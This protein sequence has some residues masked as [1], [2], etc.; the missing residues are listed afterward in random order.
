MDAVDVGTDQL[1]P[2]LRDD[3]RIT[4][5]EQTDIRAFQ[6]TTIYDIITVDVSFISLRDIIDSIKRFS[7][8]T[9][10]IFLLFKPQFEVGRENLRKT[11]VP[12]SE[13]II[14]DAI[15]GFEVFL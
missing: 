10:H 6:T 5:Y 11:G 15:S 9:T 12:K 3:P 1:H 4:L 14:L 2:S 8:H 7:D 13:M